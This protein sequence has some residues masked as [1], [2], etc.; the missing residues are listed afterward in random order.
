[1]FVG[2]SG[3]PDDGGLFESADNI[4]RN[5]PQDHWMASKPRSGGT[6]SRPKICNIGFAPSYLLRLV[7]C[8]GADQLPQIYYSFDILST[9]SYGFIKG[10]AVCFYY[11]I[12]CPRG[13]RSGFGLVTLAAGLVVAIWTALFVILLPLQCGT[14]FSVKWASDPALRQKY[15]G[16]W[17]QEVEAWTITD[18]VL[19][20]L[21]IILPVPL[22]RIPKVHL[23]RFYC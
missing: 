23:R 8:L 19:D 13:I 21:I 20:F 14:H 9:L 10:S 18:A 2:K 12:F 16:S 17:I 15:C 1:M 22:V 7:L 4:H 5:T 11:R 6:T 3:C